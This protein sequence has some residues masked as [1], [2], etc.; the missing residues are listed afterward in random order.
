MSVLSNN[1]G[2]QWEQPTIPTLGLP[3]PE[4]TEQRRSGGVGHLKGDKKRSITAML[5]ISEVKKYREYDREGEHDTGHSAE[6][7]QEIANELKSGGAIKEPLMLEHSTKHQWGYLGE[8]HHRLAAA[9]LAGHSHVPV[10][11]YSGRSGWGPGE[12]KKKG[13]GAPLTFNKEGRNLM[14]GTETV[15]EDYQPEE[16]HPYLFKEFK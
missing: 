2:R 4:G 10:F 11:V 7:I 9:E 15:G 6:R 13:I 16:M 8:G 3:I 14:G 5:P 12:R 1:L